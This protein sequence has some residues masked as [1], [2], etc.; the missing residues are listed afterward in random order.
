MLVILLRR[1]YNFY[2]RFRKK[3]EEPIME[4]LF[5]TLKYYKV[6]LTK[7][8]DTAELEVATKLYQSA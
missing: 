6:V 4:T 7:N 8:P 5:N 3:L 2:P 1:L